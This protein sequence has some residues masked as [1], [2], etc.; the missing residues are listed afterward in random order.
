MQRGVIM[1]M[2]VP[3]WYPKLL[4]GADGVSGQMSYVV[5]IQWLYQ[6]WQ[7][8]DEGCWKVRLGVEDPIDLVCS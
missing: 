1:F 5:P 6:F 8:M 7:S 3:Y 2:W 4:E